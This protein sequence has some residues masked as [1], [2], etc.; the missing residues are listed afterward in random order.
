[1]LTKKARKKN[2]IYPTQYTAWNSVRTVLSN[3]CQIFFPWGHAI[4]S[5][6]SGRLSFRGWT[7]TPLKISLFCAPGAIGYAT[8][9]GDALLP[10][11]W[12][13]KVGIFFSVY[14]TPGWYLIYVSFVTP[15][16]LGDVKLV[17]ICD[18][19]MLQCSVQEIRSYGKSC[20]T[21]ALCGSEVID[22]W[23]SLRVFDEFRCIQ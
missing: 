8:F 19:N 5:K 7:N 15:E 3:N 14:S 2:P 20:Q 11:T 22:V 10:S 16:E 18:W 23:Q 13:R 17:H 12:V 9:L 4:S 1:M 21:L 6:L